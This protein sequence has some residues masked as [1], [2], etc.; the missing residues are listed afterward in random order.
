MISDWTLAGV[1]WVGLAEPDLLPD[2]GPDFGPDLDPAGLPVVFG[3][4]AF[5]LWDCETGKQQQTTNQA[6]KSKLN[7]K[8]RKRIHN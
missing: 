4:E 6:T 8:E 7:W 3:A 2:F 5:I 1:P